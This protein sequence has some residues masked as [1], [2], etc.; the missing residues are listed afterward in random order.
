MR[1]GKIGYLGKA[2][3]RW[4][5]VSPGAGVSLQLPGTSIPGTVDGQLFAVGAMAFLYSRCCI[6]T[7][8]AENQNTSARPYIAEMTNPKAAAG[9]AMPAAADANGSSITLAARSPKLSLPAVVANDVSAS[10]S[11]ALKGVLL[12]GLTEMV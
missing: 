2:F 8:R 3:Q 5:R 7:Q 6:K 12:V 4:H 11:T 10:F 1:P 9:A